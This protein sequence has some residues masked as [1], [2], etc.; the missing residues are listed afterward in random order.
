[1]STEA[2]SIR[3]SITIMSCIWP[4]STTMVLPDDGFEL[5]F[6]AEHLA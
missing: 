6:R 3:Y 5:Q 2:V 4:A 1:M